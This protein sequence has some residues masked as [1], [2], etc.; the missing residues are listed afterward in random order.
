VTQH[1]LNLEQLMA[2]GLWLRRRAP[3]TQGGSAPVPVP[4]QWRELEGGGA[5]LRASGAGSH[6]RTQAGVEGTEA[7]SFAG[8]GRRPA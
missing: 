6:R 2:Q 3:D 4:G 7:W 8:P 5:S 1:A